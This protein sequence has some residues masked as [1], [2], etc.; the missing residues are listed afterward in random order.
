M[1][2][3]LEI[4]QQIDDFKLNNSLKDLYSTNYFETV[5]MINEKGLVTI[6]VKENP[7]IQKLK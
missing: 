4:G 7:I 2:S 6:R 3:N 1:F 5:Q